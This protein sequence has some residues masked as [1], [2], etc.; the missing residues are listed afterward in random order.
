MKNKLRDNMKKLKK[1]SRKE[2]E[3]Q[4]ITLEEKK[5]YCKSI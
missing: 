5:I 4:E 3:Q 1:N 2:S